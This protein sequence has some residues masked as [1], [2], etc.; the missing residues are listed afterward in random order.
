MAISCHYY[1]GLL[2]PAEYC[3]ECVCLSVRDHISGTTHPIFAKFRLHVTD[4]RGSVLLWRRSDMLCTSSFMDDVMSA[5]K[6]RLLDIA[7]HL[8]RS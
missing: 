5:N 8:K 1:T 2:R 6:P 7:A 4:G 3:D